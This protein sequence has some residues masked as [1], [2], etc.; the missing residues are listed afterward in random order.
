MESKAIPQS[1]QRR[2]QGSY[3][4]IPKVDW[5]KL[6]SHNFNNPDWETLYPLNAKTG[7]PTGL[8]SPRL[9]CK[10]FH[11]GVYLLNKTDENQKFMQDRLPEVTHKFYKKK[12]WR[13]QYLEGAKRI[14]CRLSLG[15]GFNS[16][17]V[18]EDAFVMVLLKDTQELGWRRI[19]QHIE[20][21]PECDKDRDFARVARLGG[22]EEV[23]MLG[24]SADE[25]VGKGKVAK[26]KD[27]APS[28][29]DKARACASDIRSWF[30]AYDTDVHHMI[31]HVIH[32]V[33]GGE[34]MPE[35]PAL[36]NNSTHE[37]AECLPQVQSTDSPELTKP[38]AAAPPSV[39]ILGGFGSF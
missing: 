8:L 33:F 27:E 17:C 4:S 38:F 5:I 34:E 23:A 39:L 12:Q 1:Y 3:K 37:S 9:A 36:E 19:Q 26:K 35:A 14:L 30:M 2:Y 28:Q 10:L 25:A 21:L 32:L 16:N 7:Q 24:R 15:L 11:D 29:K 20:E 13:K 31:D 18:A 6:T 22:S